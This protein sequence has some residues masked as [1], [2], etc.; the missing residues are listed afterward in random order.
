MT[1]GAIDFIIIDLVTP[2]AALFVVTAGIILFTSGGSDNQI[3]LA[4]RML[5][6]VIIGALIIYG[7]WLIVDSILLMLTGSGADQ[8]A[9]FPWPWHT[10]KC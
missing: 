7:A 5:Y 4:K 3:S 6:G 2:L 8:P 9:G 10:I 1:K